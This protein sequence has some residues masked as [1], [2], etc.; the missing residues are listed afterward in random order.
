MDIFDMFQGLERYV[1]SLEKTT[2][3]AYEWD[4]EQGRVQKSHSP[5]YYF[6]YFAIRGTEVWI[7][8]VSS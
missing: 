4:V 5:R 8:V 2:L 1:S 6:D 3:S 7:C